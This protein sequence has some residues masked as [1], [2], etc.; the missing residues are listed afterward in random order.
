MRLSAVNRTTARAVI[1]GDTMG[2]L[3]KFYS[4]ATVVFV[5]RTLVVLAGVDDER[6]AEARNEGNPSRE[7]HAAMDPE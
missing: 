6:G 1:L 7:N 5:G 4:L 2:E 3:R